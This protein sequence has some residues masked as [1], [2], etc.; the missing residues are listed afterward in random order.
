MISTAFMMPPADAGAPMPPSDAERRQLGRLM[1]SDGL[2]PVFQPILDLRN[3]GYLGFEALIRGPA[4]TP[5]QMPAALFDLAERCGQTSEFSR[6]CREV[7]LE[8]FA[9]LALPGMLFINVS[10]SCLADPR[11]LDSDTTRLLERL[12]LPPRRIVIEITENQQ[13]ADFSAFRDVLAAYRRIGYRI[14]VDDLGEGFSNLRMWSEVRPDFVK[15]DRHFIS[16]IADDAMKF[17]LVKAMHELAEISHAQLIAEG[18]ETEAEFATVRDLGIDFGQG[19]LI[20]RPAPDPERDPSQAVAELLARSQRIVFPQVTATARTVCSLIRKVPPVAPTTSNEELYARFETSPELMVIPVVDAAGLPLGLV[21]RYSL[22]DRFARPFRR[23][24][25]GRKPCTLLMDAQPLVLDHRTAIQEAGRMLGQSA[26]HHM[27]D[28]FIISEDGRY[29]GVGST[30]D[31]MVLITDMQMRAARYA[32]P[33]TQL[34]GNV[35]INE[36]IDRLLEGAAPFIACYCD[37]DNFKPYNDAYGY[38][39][40]DEIIQYLG[41]LLTRHCDP[42]LDFLGHIGGDD[43]VLLLQ[44]PHWQESLELVVAEFQHGMGAFLSAEHLTLG[45]YWGEDRRGKAVFHLPPTLSVGCVPVGP[46]EFHSHHEV[47][48]AMSMA[49]KQ[50]K[51][52]HGGRH[53]F[54]E[55]RHYGGVPRPVEPLS[56]APH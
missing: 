54:I 46:G 51:K 40:G 30:Q 25:F 43:F 39:R 16:G 1:T 50:A 42:R 35:P 12:G 3:R 24:L 29:R 41:A 27:L 36:H 23:E 56:T 4:G 7:A 9:R 45:G 20:A 26:Q 44:Q 8:G 19:F 17:H 31:L 53:L 22:T 28:G 34:P 33:L 55:R 18:I 21:N 48:A 49:K 5:W 2:T 37:I 11:F 52:K 15:I 10:A 47:A 38:R 13:V 32:N 6:R 14:A